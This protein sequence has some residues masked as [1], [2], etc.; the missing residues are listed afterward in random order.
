MM[1]PEEPGWSGEKYE[2]VLACSR[3]VEVFRIRV[4]RAPNLIPIGKLGGYAGT[5]IF[6]QL[7]RNIDQ[8]MKAGLK[9]YTRPGFYVS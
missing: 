2:T 1:K 9:A 5:G 6:G 7:R 3:E 4:Y 8:L